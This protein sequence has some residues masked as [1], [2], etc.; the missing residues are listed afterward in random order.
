LEN[1][2]IKQ[3]ILKLAKYEIGCNVI[4][5]IAVFLAFTLFIEKCW[6]SSERFGI[7]HIFGWNWRTL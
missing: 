7:E 2:P 3:L 4:G 5:N 6:T 1:L